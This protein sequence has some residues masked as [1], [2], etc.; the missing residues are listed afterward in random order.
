MYKFIRENGGWD[1]WTFEIIEKYPCEIEI[2]LR[3][4]ERDYYDLLNPVLNMIR[5][6]IS[7]E[8]RK[9][10]IKI[11]KAKYYQDNI[12]LFKEKSATY[13]EEHIEEIKEY[14]EKYYEE[15]REELLKLREKYYEE[16]R[17]EILKCNKQKHICEC[18]GKYT[19]NGKSQ[20]LN[21]N[22]HKKYI[23]TKKNNN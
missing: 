11:N 20:H 8:E 3:I 9:E 2:E 6:Y 15:H 4:R 10:E 5:P 12:E 19:T 23:E 13:R 1:T 16:H 22:I 14:K 18:G 17:E 7:E 21:T